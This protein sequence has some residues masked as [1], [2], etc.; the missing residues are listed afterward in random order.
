VIAR[1]IARAEPVKIRREFTGAF[2]SLLSFKDASLVEASSLME[3]TMVR[4]W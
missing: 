1:P 2:Y 3:R 4:Y